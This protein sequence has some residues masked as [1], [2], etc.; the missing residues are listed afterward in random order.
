M[1]DYTDPNYMKGNRVTPDEQDSTN[2][3]GGNIA[4]VDYPTFTGGTY[5]RPEYLDGGIS[6]GRYVQGGRYVNPGYGRPYNRS[7]PC[8]DPGP[9]GPY[10]RH[11]R[12]W[13]V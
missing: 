11:H 12:N 3:T 10:V 6:G 1:A 8:P 9:Y 2:D 7:Y 4:S 13:L 5:L